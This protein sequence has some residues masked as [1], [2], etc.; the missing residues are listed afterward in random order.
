[1]HGISKLLGG[2]SCIEK[3]SRAGVDVANYPPL[4]VQLLHRFGAG[5]VSQGFFCNVS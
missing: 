1:M 2:I 3:K 5:H 4:G